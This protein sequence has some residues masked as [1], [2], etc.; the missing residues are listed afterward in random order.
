MTGYK[1][2]FIYIFSFFS[3]YYYLFFDSEFQTDY[4][5]NHKK[6]KEKIKEKPI[7]IIYKRPL[8]PDDE[9][10]KHPSG[11]LLRDH[12]VINAFLLYSFYLL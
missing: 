3:H 6:G 5:G 4:I 9:I 8:N 12:F 10:N 7:I 11:L 2:F 1:A